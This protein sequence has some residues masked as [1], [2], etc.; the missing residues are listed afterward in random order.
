M[1]ADCFQTAGG[2]SAHCVAEWNGSS[3]SALGSG[4]GG[5]FYPYVFGLVS[6]GNDLYVAGLYTIAGGMTANGIAKWNGTSW[7]TLGSG[8][9]NGG[10]NA[11]GAYAITIYNNELVATGIF[12]T[13]G[14]TGASNIAK[15]DGLLT[16][17]KNPNNSVPDKFTLSQNYPN[18]FNPS[19]KI[20]FTVPS[21][22]NV[23][24]VIYNILGKEV[25]SL[26]NKELTPGNY[27][28]QWD[29]AN[30][31]SGDYFYRMKTNGFTETKKMI[32]V[33]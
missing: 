30:Y 32:L 1:Q 9:Y 17:T 7:A 20:K 29:A 6:F 21:K 33:K 19:T 5:G 14:G 16:G 24:L 10:S 28:V 23:S 2:V 22:S 12:S 27:E 13:A 31:P 25:A 3:W 8:F 15:W 4:C 11:Y 26:V 18:P